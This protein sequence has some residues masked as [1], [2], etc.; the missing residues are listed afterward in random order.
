MCYLEES[1]TSSSHL[2]KKFFFVDETQVG[3][4]FLPCQ[5]FNE[6]ECK[7]GEEIDLREEINL[8]HKMKINNTT[9]IKEIVDSI[10]EITFEVKKASGKS[11]YRRTILLSP[12]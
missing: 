4:I 1:G 11:Y 9:S 6:I 7:L 2:Q 10:D 12:K 3:S 8:S 5:K